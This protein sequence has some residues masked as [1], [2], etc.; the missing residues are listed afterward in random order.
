MKM[1]K[2]VI[3]FAVAMGLVGG[4]YQLSMHLAVERSQQALSEPAYKAYVASR[5]YATPNGAVTKEMLLADVSTLQAVHQNVGAPL[6][7]AMLVSFANRFGLDD[8]Y[9]QTIIE[10]LPKLEG[11]ALVDNV[12]FL[13]LARSDDEYV[14]RLNLSPEAEAV[15]DRCVAAVEQ[16]IALK[17]EVAF[18]KLDTFQYGLGLPRLN[19]SDDA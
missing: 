1:K 8:V 14:P 19:C 18:E 15:L 2:A 7:L 11:S 6:S 10:E 9:N 12:G 3:G 13:D 17:W 5:T 16:S 4:A